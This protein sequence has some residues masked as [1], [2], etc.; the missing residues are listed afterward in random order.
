MTLSRLGFILLLAGG[1][2]A[3]GA[4]GLTVT[5]MD[6]KSR[7]VEGAVVIARPADDVKVRPVTSELATI[8]QKGKEFIPHVSPIRAGT[9]VQFPNSDNIRHHV[10]SFSSAKKFEIP[11]YKGTPAKP[12]VF[13]KPGVVVL[14]CNIHDW[15]TAYVYVSDVPYLAVT[16]KDGTTTIKELPTGTY[17]VEVWHPQMRGTPTPRRHQVSLNPTGPQKVVFSIKQKKAWRAR[18]L[19]SNLRRGY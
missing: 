4:S 10:Y 9:K 2:H 3:G 5:V 7:P 19:S 15:M 13:D 17:K 11:L 18:R 6:D 16:E 8:D 1:S 12:I 14:G